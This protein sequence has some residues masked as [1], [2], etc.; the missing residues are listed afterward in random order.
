MSFWFLE[1]QGLVIL[2]MA[3]ESLLGGQIFPLDLLPAWLFKVSSAL[4]YFYQMYFPVALLTGRINDPAAVGH[5]LMIRRRGSSR[6]SSSARSSGGA[7]CACT[8]PSA[9]ELIAESRMRTAE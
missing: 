9:D 8:P 1:I 6:F 2:S 3:I 5:M 4:P 7:A